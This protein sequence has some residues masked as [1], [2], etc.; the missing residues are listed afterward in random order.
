M[1]Y[2]LKNRQYTGNADRCRKEVDSANQLCLWA[3]IRIYKRFV[4]N[5]E[6]KK[7]RKLYRY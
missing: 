2:I 6:Q 4:G 7:I 5:D 1:R 3:S